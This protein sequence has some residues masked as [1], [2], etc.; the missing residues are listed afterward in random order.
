MWMKRPSGATG[1]DG[2]AR[3]GRIQ[4]SSTGAN[5]N[6]MSDRGGSERATPM[7]AQYLEIKRAHPGCLLF[8]RMGDFYELF[9]DDAEVA[10]RALGIALTK[11]GRH[12]GEDIPMCGVPVHAAGDYL[13]R[14]IRA[15]HRVAVCEQTEAPEEAKKRGAKS[16]VRRAVT[17]IVT[18]GTLTEDSLLDADRHNYLVALARVRGD[19]ALGL[20]WV[21]I[22]TGDL[23]VAPVTPGDLASELARL[24]PGEIVFSEPLGVEAGIIRVLKEQGAALT[25][26]PASRFDSTAGERRLKEHFEVAA[27][28]AFGDLTRAETAAAGGLLD[29]V[30]LTQVGHLPAIR[31]PRR[32]STGSAMLID[33]ATRTNLELVRT[34]SGERRGSLLD[35]I[36]LTVSGAG[37]RLL[38]SW[39]ASPLTRVGG[40]R[41]AA[42]CGRLAGA[43]RRTAR[44]VCASC[45]K[46]LPI[47]IARW[48]GS[49]SGAAARAILPPSAAV[50]MSPGKSPQSWRRQK[51]SIRH[52]S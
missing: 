50:W 52:P 14:L 17:R 35:C 11:R 27:L 25:P 30:L 41:G 42:R 49:A 21:D 38:A 47:L 26:L 9:F 3:F 43:A 2:F 51:R 44:T 5:S 18:P 7:M 48:R 4:A 32:S 6:A 31:P 28:E 24:D 40:D 19:D 46:A 23:E 33:A 16:V 22:S 1:V 37:G 36:D 15:G 8:Y 39:L 34:T 20:A 13:Q 12:L 10:S 29:Y 45:S